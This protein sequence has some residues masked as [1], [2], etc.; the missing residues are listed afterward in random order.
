[1]IGNIMEE[2]EKLISENRLSEAEE[3]LEQA[4]ESARADYL[5]GRLAW[6]RGDRAGAMSLYQ[7]SAELEPDGPAAVALEQA[8]DIMAFYHKDLYNP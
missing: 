5:R 3:L 7:R 8:R 4:G 6:R 2:I 1:M